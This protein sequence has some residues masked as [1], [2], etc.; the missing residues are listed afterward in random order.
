MDLVYLAE[1]VLD[2]TSKMPREEV[3]DGLEDQ[4][5]FEAPRLEQQLA[6][7]KRLAEEA[8]KRA[9]LAEARVDDLEKV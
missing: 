4:F 7:S 3:N 5:D 1:K 8:E 6:E 9:T 2:M